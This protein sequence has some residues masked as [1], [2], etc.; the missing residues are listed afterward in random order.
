MAAVYYN[1]R[2]VVQVLLEAGASRTARDTTDG[3]KRTAAEWARDEGYVDLARYIDSFGTPLPPASWPPP[4]LPC[5]P[6][7]L[8]L[9]STHPFAPSHSVLC[10]GALFLCE[11]LC[12]KERETEGLLSACVCM[13]GVCVCGYMSCVCV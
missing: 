6:R 11:T 9:C 3:S 8:C 7:L 13:M 10:D 12:E 2:A 4:F 1:Y 5:S